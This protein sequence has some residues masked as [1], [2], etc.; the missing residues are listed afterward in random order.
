[1]DIRS[2]ELKTRVRISFAQLKIK[3]MEKQVWGES[4][5]RA[6]IRKQIDKCFYLTAGQ[7]TLRSHLFDPMVG[8][9]F[10]KLHSFA[11]DEIRRYKQYLHGKVPKYF[12]D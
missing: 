10:G 6:F 8:W 4:E 2:G 3:M 1:L 9:R 5:F 12:E 11:V 7:L